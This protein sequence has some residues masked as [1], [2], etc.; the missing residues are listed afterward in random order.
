[1]P[2]S[3]PLPCYRLIAFMFAFIVALVVALSYALALAAALAVTDALVS[4]FLNAIAIVYV[5]DLSARV[6]LFHGI[7]YLFLEYRS[8]A[9]CLCRIRR[10]SR[11]RM[12]QA[13]KYGGWYSPSPFTGPLDL[14]ASIGMELPSSISNLSFSRWIVILSRRSAARYRCRNGMT[15]DGDGKM[16]PFEMGFI[17]IRWCMFN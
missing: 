8:N 16:Y 17:L 12:K 6:Q 14:V 13:H 15:E 9:S 5:L 10:S 2:L 3:T 11:W 7:C 4:T 1:M